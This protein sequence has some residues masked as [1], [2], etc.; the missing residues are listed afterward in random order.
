MQHLPATRRTQ[1]SNRQMVASVI[2]PLRQQ[3]NHSQPHHQPIRTSPIYPRQHRMENTMTQLD[4]PKWL[5]PTALNYANQHSPP[6]WYAARYAITGIRPPKNV[7]GLR[8]Q[9]WED[10]LQAVHD[11]IAREMLI[12]R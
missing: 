5:E 9:G 10:A 7:Y 4:E 11:V 2:N 12:T 3:Q 8:R 1:Q 6:R